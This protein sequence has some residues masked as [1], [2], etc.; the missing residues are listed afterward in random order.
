[1]SK[2]LS[3]PLPATTAL[4]KLGHDLALARRKREHF[5][6]GHSGQALC[7]RD[8]LWRLERGD[9][10]VALGTLA[11]AAFIFKLHDR[12]ASLF[13]PATDELALALDERRIP[14]RIRR[15]KPLD[16]RSS[17]RLDGRDPFGRPPAPSDQGNA[18]TFEYSAD[19]LKRDRCCMV[20]LLGTSSRTSR[21]LTP[22]SSVPC[23]TAGR[24]DGAEV[25]I[26][27]AVRKEDLGPKAL[28]GHRLCLGAGRLNAF[29]SPAFPGGQW[30][31][32]GQ[33]PAEPCRLW[34]A[35]VS[36]C[37]PPKPS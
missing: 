22:G 32:S 34:C 8:T 5:H 10:S 30:Q 16:A 19:W 26:E 37:M 35:W 4:R 9:P 6:G 17:Y 1:M 23:M 11:T 18:V 33:S 13:A 3:I 27:Q 14:Q 15:V 24:I 21:S 36:F 2:T 12:V 31:P 28:S 25:L 29:R 7:R 20:E